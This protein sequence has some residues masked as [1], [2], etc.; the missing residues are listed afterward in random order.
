MV[1]TAPFSLK[2]HFDKE[3]HYVC[4]QSL[5]VFSNE[6]ILS[7]TMMH[8]NYEWFHESVKENLTNY[9][10]TNSDILFEGHTHESKIDT[11]KNNDY[12][13]LL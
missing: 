7:I 9:I 6:G 4:P 13:N 3:M 12:N 5:N 8:H 1:N 11:V 10:F 2:S